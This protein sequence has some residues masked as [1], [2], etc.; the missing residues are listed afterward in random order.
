MAAR[1]VRPVKRTSSTRRT[2]FLGDGKSIRSSSAMGLASK[3][4]M[5]SR[6]GSDVQD[7]D[8]DLDAFHLPDE[9]GDALAEVDAPGPDA[10]DDHVL[11]VA[12]ALD[13]LRGHAVEDVA[14]SW[15]RP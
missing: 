10:D 7:A 1:M 8:R 3:A 6:K 13:D 12:V 15:W 9:P 14:G 2:S 4:G 5:S 11:E